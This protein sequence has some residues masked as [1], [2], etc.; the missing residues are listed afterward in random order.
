MGARTVTSFP[1]S[2]VLIGVPTRGLI[3]VQTASRLEAIRDNSPGLRPIHYQ[4]GA[5]NVA[6]NRNLIVDYFLRSTKCQVLIFCDDDVVPPLSILE[7][8]L[9]IPEEFGIVGVPYPI[10]DPQSGIPAFCV[11]EM[12]DE[13][14][15][16]AADV[17][18]NPGVHEC[19]AVATGCVAIPRH[20]LEHLG[21]NCFRFDA[22]PGHVFHG[23]DILFCRDVRNAGWKVG[24][25]GE[26]G[27]C[28]HIRVTSLEPMVMLID[29]LLMS[30]P[31][32]TVPS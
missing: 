24:Y 13:L 9:P 3:T 28:D 2:D 7:V 16:R 29:R 30:L 27:F 15:I 17:A 12:N 23:E 6:Y 11:Y 21:S 4:P 19:D 5:A 25:V 22:H 20:V 14:G 32:D 18:W 31:A 26:L 10:A 8:L 1:M